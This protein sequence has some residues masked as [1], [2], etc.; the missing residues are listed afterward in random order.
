MNWYVTQKEADLKQ[1]IKNIAKPALLVA[2]LGVGLGFLGNN[3]PKETQPAPVVQPSQPSGNW[4]Q[5]VKEKPATQPTIQPST[6]PTTTKT[7]PASQPSVSLEDMLKDHEGFSLSMYKDSEGIPTIGIGFNLQKPGAKERIE[8]LGYSYK[9]IISGEQKI[10][11][12]A[13]SMLFKEDVAT[14]RK[15]ISSV[16][17]ELNSHP[18]IVQNVLTDM[19][20]NMGINRFSG[21]EN[22]ILA[23]NQKDYNKAADE[24]ENSKWYG[25]VK[26]R[27]PALVKLMRSVAPAT[28]P[29]TK[30]TTVPSSTQ[31]SL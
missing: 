3:A 28:Q 22:M 23:L 14:A 24:M 2:P 8:A 13:A 31:P 21:F 16:I 25:Q 29:A 11:H 4:L 1:R 30:P 7:E 20:F 10:S 18:Q 17:P 19:M 26:R 27:G 9:S 15:D 5:N 6:Q 12:Q